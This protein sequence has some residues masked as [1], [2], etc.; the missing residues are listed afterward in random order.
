M[1]ITPTPAPTQTGPLATQRAHMDR[2]KAEVEGRIPREFT[3]I[4]GI[5][6]RPLVPQ[7]QG[8]D[9]KRQIL[10]EVSANPLETF[11][12]NYRRIERQNTGLQTREFTYISGIR[13][14]PLIPQRQG[15]DAKRQIQSEAVANP[16]EEI[17]KMY[18]IMKLQN[19]GLMSRVHQFVSGVQTTPL[20]QNQ[21]EILNRHVT[22][23][24]KAIEAYRKNA[25]PEPPVGSKLDILI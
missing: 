19:Q 17:Q 20:I 4:S 12:E 7:R 15:F 8:F 2:I 3:Y 14:N 18:E 13:H 22:Q 23:N 11:M 16:L 25:K 6:H 24:L 10:N 5:K 21:S 1:R 9:A